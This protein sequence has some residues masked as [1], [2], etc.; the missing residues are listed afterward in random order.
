VRLRSPR[1]AVTLNAWLT[2][3]VPP[4]VLSTTF[5]FPAVPINALTGEGADTET[6]CP[7]FKVVAAAIERV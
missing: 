5:H 6:L 4:G 3:R 1:G 7:E 2:D